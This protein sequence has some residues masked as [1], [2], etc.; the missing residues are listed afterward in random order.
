MGAAIVRTTVASGEV[1]TAVTDPGSETEKGIATCSPLRSPLGVTVGTVS[2]AAGS[3]MTGAFVSMTKS[4]V[5]DVLLPAL[6]TAVT[7]TVC[8]PSPLTLM[9]SVPRAAASPPSTLNRFALT[10]DVASL[11]AASMVT[12][13]RQ[14]PSAS[15]AVPD[16]TRVTTGARVSI[17]SSTDFQASRTP[18]LSVAR[19][20]SV[21]TP[22]P[23]MRTGPS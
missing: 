19:Y 17:L 12:G 11:I 22:S 8:D 21:R 23:V 3:L 16:G 4:S 14:V 13:P 10:P 5:V 1:T 18:A 2:V 20:S 6:S 15:P 7:A 9:G